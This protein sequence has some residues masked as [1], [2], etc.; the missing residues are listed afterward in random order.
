MKERNN[1]AIGNAIPPIIAGSPIWYLAALGMWL[2]PHW[3]LGIF[4]CLAGPVVIWL[5]VRWVNRGSGSSRA[6][7]SVDA[8]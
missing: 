7:P 5:C 3:A 2:H 6:K 1:N 4:G 8:R